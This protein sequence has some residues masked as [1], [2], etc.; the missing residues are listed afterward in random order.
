MSSEDE[1]EVRAMDGE[2]DEDGEEDDDLMIIIR[3][4]GRRIDRGFLNER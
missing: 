3:A 2:D 1:D 4:C